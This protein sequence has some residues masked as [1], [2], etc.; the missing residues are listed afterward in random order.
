M[1]TV[2][3]GYRMHYETAGDG[4][5]LLFIQGGLGG[6]LTTLAPREFFLAQFLGDA[7]TIVWYDRR[8]AG[9]SDYPEQ[10]Y[11]LEEVAADAR[12]LLDHL[13]VEKAVVMGD[14][15]GGPIALTFALSF[16]ER[17]LGLVAAETS[18]VLEEIPAFDP[19]QWEVLKVL[20]EDG[21]EAAYESRRRATAERDDQRP[22]LS[23]V[24]DFAA[25]PPEL[26]H[27]FAT[28]WQEGTK[29]AKLAS[30]EDRVRWYAGEL[31]NL[32]MYEGV[33]LRPRLPTISLPTCVI[34]GERDIAVPVAHGRAIAELIPG[35]E[36][37]V[38]PGVQHGVMLSQKAR[39][40]LRSFLD[41]VSSRR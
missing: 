26:K 13:G 32:A 7:H 34:H 36:L 6:M 17:C 14:S 16:P 4:P 9:Q 30:R 2:V 28:Q 23:R 31:R 5:P 18:A 33:D 40:A 27:F 35:A 41:R 1:E 21:P 19:R 8:S 22:P 11:G 29:R 20:R 39:D 15:A 3:N 24:F 12:G 37:Q 25:A 38:V 10:F